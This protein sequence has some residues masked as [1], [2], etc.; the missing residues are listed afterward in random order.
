MSWALTKF[1]SDI[2]FIQQLGDNPNFDN[3]MSAEELKAWFD[4]A[5]EAIKAFIN[6]TLIAEL[7]AK[8]GEVAQTDAGVDVLLKELIEKIQ[9]FEVGAGFIPIDGDVPMTGNLNLSNHRIINVDSPVDPYDAVNRE[10]VDNRTKTVDVVLKKNAWSTSI[11]HNQTVKISNN[12]GVPIVEDSDYPFVDV[13]LNNVSDQQ[14][15]IEGW[16]LVGRV[17]VSANDQITAYCYDDIPEVDVP[18]ILRVVR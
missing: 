17:T 10:Y 11:P 15:A 9:F 4:K 6:D 3:N 8:F 18:L 5:P 1:T 7:E 13:N 16:G 14:S 2:A 12:T